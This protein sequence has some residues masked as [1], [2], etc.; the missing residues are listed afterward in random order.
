MPDDETHPVMA[1]Q[2]LDRGRAVES[3]KKV[4]EF[5]ALYAPP[6]PAAVIPDEAALRALAEEENNRPLGRLEIIDR[7]KAAK[8]NQV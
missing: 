4:R 3:L 5:H 2:L 7:V 6:P 8:K 1:I